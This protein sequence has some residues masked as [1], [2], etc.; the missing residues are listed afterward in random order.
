MPLRRLRSVV[1]RRRAHASGTAQGR[2]RDGRLPGACRPEGAGTRRRD[3]A[4]ARKQQCNNGCGG[5][6][7]AR[8]AQSRA[9]PAAR[10]EGGR[11]DRA[12]VAQAG[13][14]AC[15]SAGEQPAT[16]LRSSAFARGVVGTAGCMLTACLPLWRS[17]GWIAWAQGCRRTSWGASDWHGGAFAWRPPA[18][19]EPQARRAL[20]AAFWRPAAVANPAAPLCRKHRCTLRVPHNVLHPS[21]CQ[22]H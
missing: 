5:G 4:S 18:S 7:A 10:P 6:G 13:A 17:A 22:A 8:R 15:C 21:L 9:A 12:G 3:T 20:Q 16:S 2:R 14:Q 19:R 11:E 1:N